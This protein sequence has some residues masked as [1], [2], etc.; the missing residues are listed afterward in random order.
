[1]Y[2]FV[3]NSPLKVA[4]V[5][6]LLIVQAEGVQGSHPLAR[7]TLC[8]GSPWRPPRQIAAHMKGT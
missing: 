3:V 4:N 5:F 7:R 8:K 1:M 6:Y 2:R